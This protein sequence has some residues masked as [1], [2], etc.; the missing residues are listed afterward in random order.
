MTTDDK[1]VIVARNKLIEY[2]D[3]KRMRKTPERFAILDVV[4]S[5]KTILM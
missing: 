1:T 3:N 4:Y 5:A 2:L